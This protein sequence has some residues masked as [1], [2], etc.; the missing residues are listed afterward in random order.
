VGEVSAGVH[1]DA[2]LAE[3]WDYYFDPEGWAGWVDGFGQVESASGYPEEGGTLRWRSGP[4]GRGEV[5]EQVLEHEPRRL[6]RI[7][8]S[9]PESSGELLTSF[10]IVGE[11]TEVVQE[12]TYTPRQMGALGPLTDW[13]F[14]R[15]QVRR[16]LVRSL[17][18]F[19]AEL[20]ELSAP[21]G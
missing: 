3:T 2:D 21:D 16:S 8:F 4:A 15:S 11:G 12:M 20:E 18:A 9:D 17:A 7:S 1:V 5:T 13:L 19:K 10:R 14:V 6:H